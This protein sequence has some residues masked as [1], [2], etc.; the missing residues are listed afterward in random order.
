[1]REV[2]T[3]QMHEA[4]EGIERLTKMMKTGEIQEPEL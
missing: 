3:Q 4:A 1:M 2:F